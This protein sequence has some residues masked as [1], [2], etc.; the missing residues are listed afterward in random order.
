MYAHRRYGCRQGL[1]LTARRL[2]RSSTQDQETERDTARQ[3]DCK[4]TDAAGSTGGQ[5]VGEGMRA[6]D[7]AQLVRA[8]HEEVERLVCRDP[9]QY[10]WAHD[11]WKVKVRAPV[12]V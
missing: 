5:K 12:S 9:R 1:Y 6:S 11:R 7:T 3:R 4:G 8:Y 10:L 2:S